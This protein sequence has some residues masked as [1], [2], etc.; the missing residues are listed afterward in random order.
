MEAN[1]VSFMYIKRMLH[2]H[3]IE[4]YPFIQHVPSFVMKGFLN[5]GASYCQIG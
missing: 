5:L 2:L 1:W 4:K 3:M